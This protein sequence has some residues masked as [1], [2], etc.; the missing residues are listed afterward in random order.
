MIKVHILKFSALAIAC[1]FAL[2]LCATTHVVTNTNNSGAG[3]L[4]SV[5]DSVGAGDTVR[6]ADSLI[7][8]GN[9]TIILSSP[10][11]ITEGFFLKGLF[12]ANDSLFI[13]GNGSNRVFDIDLDTALV[14]SL[15]LDSA[16][17]ID[18]YSSSNGGAVF[19]ENGSKLALYRSVFI[20][21]ES[22]GRGG[23][24]YAQERARIRQC[25]FKANDAVNS[26]AVCGDDFI[27]VRYSQFVGNTVSGVGGAIY[28]NTSEYNGVYIRDCE[29]YGNTADYGGALS[30][31]ITNGT[32]VSNCYFKNNHAVNR[33]GAFYN[34]T[35]SSLKDCIFEDNSSDNFGGAVY[36][37]SGGSIL[38]CIFINNESNDDGG[39]VFVERNIQIGR[40]AFSGNHTSANSALGGAVCLNDRGNGNIYDCAFVNNYNT[41]SSAKGGA[42]GLYAESTT[43]LR[44]LDLKTS[45]FV[46][47]F[48]SGNSSRGGAIA[49][50][51]AFGSTYTFEAKIEEC[52]FDS[53]WAKDFGGA[54]A[55]LTENIG[56]N[57]SLEVK[58]SEF[59]NN[60]VLDGIGG[61]IFIDPDKKLTVDILRTT[62]AGNT[63]EAGAGIWCDMSS[64]PGVILNIH[65][66]TISNNNCNGLLFHTG[67][68]LRMSRGPINLINSTIFDNT[69]DNPDVIGAQVYLW[70]Y[71]SIFTQSSIIVGDDSSDL[72]IFHNDS[73][74][75]GGYNLI[76]DTGFAFT[77]ATDSQG[78][79]PAS[80]D[81]GP[82]ALNGGY[83]HTMIPS[84]FSK[85]FNAGT[86]TDFVD[87]QNLPTNGQRDV[88]A[89]EF[90]CN[91]YQSMSVV[92]C[93][94]FTSPSGNY[95]YYS[96][97][98]YNITDSLTTVL[99]CDS[100]FYI[101]LIV[102]EPDTVVD[103]ILVCDIYY[104]TN[105]SI[106]LTMSG[107]Y[108]TVLNNVNGC[109]SN[110]S[111]NLTVLESTD[112]SIIV[113]ACN[114]YTTPSG[115]QTFTNA[116]I[117]L[118]YDTIL[119]VVGCDSVLFIDLHLYSSDT[120]LHFDT[121][122]HDYYWPLTDSTYNNS[123]TFYANFTNTSGCDSTHVLVLTIHPEFHD[124]FAIEACDSF[125]WISTDSVYTTSVNHT[126]EFNSIFG[127]DSNSTLSLTIQNS[128][129]TSI[130]LMACDSFL[131]P[132][133]MWLVGAGNYNLLDTLTNQFG[134]DS[135]LYIDLTINTSEEIWD[136]VAVCGNYVWAANGQSY[137]NSG[138]Y[139]ASFQNTNGCDSTR[140]LDLTVHPIV[141]QVIEVTACD[142]F[143]WEANAK[144]LFLSG[145]YDTLYTSQ[146]GCDS[147][148]TLD[149]TIV[150]IDT[151][152]LKIG[153]SLVANQPSASYQW[154]WCEQGFDTIANANEQS[155]KANVSGLYAVAIEDAGC[156]DTSECHWV[157]PLGLHENKASKQPFTVFPNPNNGVL[158]ILSSLMKEYSIEMRGGNGQLVFSAEHLGN[159]VLD[160][161]KY[162]KGVY[163][164][165]VYSG[166]S[167]LV[168]R[169]ILD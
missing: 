104:W 121:A 63:A 145:N 43:F 81:L 128:P 95:S 49:G 136:T 88:G 32:F 149:L 5:I 58:D 134:C 60:Y 119:N 7:N 135:V 163:T 37:L 111:L 65:E 160:L 64:S 153:D 113:N 56:L 75:S 34:G 20:G 79:T 17:I 44:K 90:P 57:S 130:S 18:G 162:A 61:A 161:S 148:L 165:R 141:S 126:A 30:L 59:T 66:S 101:S 117:Y 11:D 10:I 120:V 122:C 41:G 94:S 159:T 109:D 40:C 52:T 14:D 28:S 23:A 144:S 39:A 67:C 35:L 147:L 38:D 114:I 133:G 27:D 74:S 73:A 155:Y 45:T 103:T 157:A 116:G 46:G 36:F 118:I 25:L 51:T 9:A 167:V 100:V 164:I 139:Q 96:P 68:G 127:C 143:Y 166:E 152:V 158:H 156:V 31:S 3:S 92:T 151:S 132:S 137:F 115:N 80:L 69:S 62:I 83:A 26:G 29:F 123:G 107:I 105:D 125:Y 53:N 78:V 87:A 99:G 48:C 55:F 70:Q 12:T 4:R 85:A 76:S 131:L 98:I 108:D 13:S 8:S 82:L 124:T 102:D 86:P 154:L 22:G 19:F 138:V 47:N 110:V 33:G 77:S 71:A 169:L 2:S 106:A 140:Y 50:T 91:T 1:L 150:S 72:F 146:Y 97:G 93:D 42:I 21:C 16:I 168:K 112:T 15:V 54:L 129:P 6:F 24:V 142:S 84:Q 89:A